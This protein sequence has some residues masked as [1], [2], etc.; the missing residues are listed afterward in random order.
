MLDA[1]Q[2]AIMHGIVRVSSGMYGQRN[3]DSL[4]VRALGT[5]GYFSLTCLCYG[6]PARMG[7]PW[8]AREH[9]ALHV[10]ACD[11]QGSGCGAAAGERP[12]EAAGGPEGGR[13][14]RGQPQGEP[15]RYLV[16]RRPGRRWAPCAHPFLLLPRA[17]SCRGRPSLNDVCQPHMMSS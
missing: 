13:A 1:A 5:L 6:C 8:P 15:A 14:G 16:P 2:D 7:V 11:K 4:G 17:C 3:A 10:T 12:D 9:K